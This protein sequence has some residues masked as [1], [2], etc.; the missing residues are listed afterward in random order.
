M[1]DITETFAANALFTALTEVVIGHA[2]SP[3]AFATASGIRAM[4]RR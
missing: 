4:T 2:A 3:S 1:G